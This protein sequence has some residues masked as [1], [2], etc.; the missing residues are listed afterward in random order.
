VGIEARYETDTY[1]FGS[2]NLVQYD[3]D[4][5]VSAVGDIRRESCALA[6]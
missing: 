4:R 2:V 1:L 6:I 3:S 5:T